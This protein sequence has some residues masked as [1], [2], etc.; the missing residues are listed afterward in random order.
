MLLLF[1]VFTPKYH[2][3]IKSITTIAYLSYFLLR[4][5]LT[6]NKNH[7]KNRDKNVLLFAVLVEYG[8]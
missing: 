4:L 3:N 2:K 1:L 5:S 6:V 7:D 8:P